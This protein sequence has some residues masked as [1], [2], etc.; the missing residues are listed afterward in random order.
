MRSIRWLLV[1]LAIVASIAAGVL[2]S[3]MLLG[4]ALRACPAD[5]RE[6]A[7]CAASWFPQA[8][9]AIDA[10]GS[11]V[12]GFLGVALAV[13]IAPAHRPAVAV[14][15]AFCVLAA[16]TAILVL[17]AVPLPLPL[18]GGAAGGALGFAVLRRRAMMDAMRA[19]P[20]ASPDR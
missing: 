11:A 10:L 5:S 8:E 2:L 7:A 17:L 14:I 9:V 1:L 18:L 6:A 15:V 3:F 20:R 12:A 16:V 4:V 19:P 13:A